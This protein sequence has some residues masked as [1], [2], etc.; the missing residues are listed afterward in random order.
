MA[1]AELP[2]SFLTGGAARR[3]PAACE[4]VTV[5]GTWPVAALPGRWP[6]AS[7]DAAAPEPGSYY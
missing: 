2:S 6:G 1:Q 5:T 4:T 7:Q 3:G